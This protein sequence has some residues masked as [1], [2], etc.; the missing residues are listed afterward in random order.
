M[1]IRE[2]RGAAN[3]SG[4]LRELRDITLRRPQRIAKDS[5]MRT[6]DVQTDPCGR[7]DTVFDGNTVRNT[8]QACDL[9][10]DIAVGSNM[11]TGISV[12]IGEVL[13]G[14]ITVG[15]S[16]LSATFRDAG[17]AP[18]IGFDDPDLE[19][20]WGGSVKEVLADENFVAFGTEKGCIAML[21]ERRQ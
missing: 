19:R 20:D 1:K 8:G 2:S 6:F 7:S 16:K 5:I 14:E 12:H 3:L 10:G 18:H 13:E 17:Y 9:S 4:K 15:G 11:T 21:F